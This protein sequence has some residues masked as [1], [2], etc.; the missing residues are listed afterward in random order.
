[1]VV[2]PSETATMAEHQRRVMEKWFRSFAVTPA[3]R[4]QAAP[5]HLVPSDTTYPDTPNGTVRRE[6][7]GDH[8]LSFES[9]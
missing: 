3:H 4:K 6:P 2:Q 8:P 9:P 5:Y 7:D 1:M